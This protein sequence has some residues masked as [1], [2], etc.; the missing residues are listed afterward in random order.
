MTEATSNAPTL[1]AG[2]SGAYG[3]AFGWI[4]AGIPVTRS[5]HPTA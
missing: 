1:A 4:G 3:A 2:V 5:V